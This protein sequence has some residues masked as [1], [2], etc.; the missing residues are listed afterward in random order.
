MSESPFLDPFAVP[1]GE[2]ESS[3]STDVP[4]DVVPGTVVASGPASAGATHAVCA[5]LPLDLDQAVG[6]FVDDTHLWWPRALRATGEAGHVYFGD[7]GLLE[8][9]AD[10][11][12]GDDQDPP[13]EWATLAGAAEGTLELDWWGSHHDAATSP[14]R[15][16][17][18]WSAGPRGG[19]ELSVRG[20][21]PTSWWED[22]TTILGAFTRFT[23][24]SITEHGE[25]GQG[26]GG[27]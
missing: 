7:G 10:G 19:A 22:W 16:Y 21:E 18:S 27:S 1:T 11:S 9:G 20:N 23:G 8:E 26:G 2:E 5:S 13:Y 3:V 12:S 24:G 4:G 14:V 15:L 25:P 6:A 17:V